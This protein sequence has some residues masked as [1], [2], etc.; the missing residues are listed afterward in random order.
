[1]DFFNSESWF[2]NQVSKTLNLCRDIH[3]TIVKNSREKKEATKLKPQQSQ[4]NARNSFSW[5]IFYDR[6]DVN[7]FFFVCVLVFHRLHFQLQCMP[8]NAR[9]RFWW[10]GKCKIP[11]ILYIWKSCG[12]QNSIFKRPRRALLI[13]HFWHFD[14]GISFT[15]PTDII[16]E[17]YSIWWPFPGTVF[18]NVSGKWQLIE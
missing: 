10:N 9:C 18:S 3:K 16:R 2:M 8:F 11:L 17:K 6:D 5:T 15:L 4:T 7:F 1:M 12:F 13:K 14:V